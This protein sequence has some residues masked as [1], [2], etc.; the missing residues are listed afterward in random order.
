MHTQCIVMEPG[1]SLVEHLHV[2][3]SFS[4]MPFWFVPELP[5]VKVRYDKKNHEV[6]QA[7]CVE[8]V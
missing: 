1:L 7:N 5:T 2:S 3:L 4:K 8:F 6:L